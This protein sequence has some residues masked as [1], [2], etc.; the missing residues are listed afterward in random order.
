MK[1]RIIIPIIAFAILLFGVWYVNDY[2]HSEDEIC[3]YLEDS[4]NVDVA[5]IAEGIFFDGKGE[6]EAL[7]FYPGG[8]VEYTAYAPIMQKIAERGV[9]CFLL[10]MPC[11]LAILD[12]DKAKEIQNS[13]SYDIWHM[14]G[15]S[16]GGAAASAYVLNS[17]YEV[18]S[19]LLLGAYPMED[20]SQ[21]ELKVLSLYGSEDQVL[22]HEKFEEGRNLVPQNS[23]YVEI[24]GGNHAW[25]GMYG[26]QEGDGKA[27]I[28][29][30]E[31]WQITANECL[32]IMRQ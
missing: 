25:F 29:Q 17:V 9:D 7:V 15:H 3:M 13:Y 12:M 23:K 31:Q 22:N 5:E 19:L 32:D 21:T 8:K 10:K 20:L 14:G 27:V 18:E 6:K 16:L 11:N 28:T 2:Y 4:E 26:E 24:L 30:E 1:K